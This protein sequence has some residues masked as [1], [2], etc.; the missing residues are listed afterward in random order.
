MRK[1]AEA[2]REG[3][4]MIGNLDDIEIDNFEKTDLSKLSENLRRASNNSEIS[5]VLPM[6]ELLGLE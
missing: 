3:A 5:G 4:V 6:R 2:Q 1:Q